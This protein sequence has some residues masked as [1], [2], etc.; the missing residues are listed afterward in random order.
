MEINL[1]FFKEVFINS[2]NLSEKDAENLQ[3]E[4]MFEE[5]PGWD[6]L[7]HMRIIAELESQLNV[8]FELDEIIG[9]DTVDKLIQMCLTKK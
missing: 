4:S 7:G 8:E 6:S 1:N 3:L 5:V 9:V 2:I